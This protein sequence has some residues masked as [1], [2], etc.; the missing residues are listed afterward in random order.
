[1]KKDRRGWADRNPED[2]PGIREKS[3]S[4]PFAGGEIWFEHLDGMGPYAVLAVQKL[5]ADAAEFHRP[6]ATGF[7]AFVL[8]EIVMTEAL[9]SE[10]TE[11]LL[12]PGK[13]FRR[14]AFVGADGL[15]RKMLK[16]RLGGHGFAL[17]F[18]DGIEPAKE[19]LMGKEKN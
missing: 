3:F 11:A 2:L 4:L 12:W 1:M 5:R 17:R 7:I 8:D 16:K 13:Q 10:I 15:S 18:F 19:W 9:I 6:S 14:A